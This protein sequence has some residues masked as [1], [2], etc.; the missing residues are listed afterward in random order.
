M[1]VQAHRPRLF[2]HA[3]GIY[4]YLL[5]IHKIENSVERKQCVVMVT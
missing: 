5:I 3:Q 4:S 1:L 2:A